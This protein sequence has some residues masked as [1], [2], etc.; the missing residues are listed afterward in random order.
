MDNL[1]RPCTAAFDLWRLSF[2]LFGFQ[3]VLSEKVINLMF[4]T[5]NWVGKHLS[6]FGILFHYVL[7]G[8]GGNTI[9]ALLKIWKVRGLIC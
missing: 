3:R 7:C 8:L 5:R 1:S 9:D 4:C 2:R 6:D